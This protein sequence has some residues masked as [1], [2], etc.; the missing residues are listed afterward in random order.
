LEKEMQAA[1]LRNDVTRGWSRLLVTWSL[2]TSLTYIGPIVAILTLVMPAAK[3][4]PL[5]DT[6]FELMAAGHD[7]ILYPVYDHDGCDRLDRIGYSS[8]P[9]V[10]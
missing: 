10:T 4:N 9:V 8:S 3:L 7:P 5:G 1:D 6:Y 2:F